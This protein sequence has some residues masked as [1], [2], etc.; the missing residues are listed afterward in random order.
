MHHPK[1]YQ[2]EEKISGIEN[3]VRNS[4]IHTVIKENKNNEPQAQF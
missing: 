4:Y 2:S 1:T 3:K